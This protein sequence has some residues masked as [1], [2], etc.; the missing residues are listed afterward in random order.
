MLAAFLLWL[1]HVGAPLP[2]ILAVAAFCCGLLALIYA[3]TRPWR[4]I[5]IGLGLPLIAFGMLVLVLPADRVFLAAGCTGI[6]SGCA[7]A[8]IL[9]MERHVWPAGEE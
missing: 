2:Y 4:R 9:W 8:A 1:R 5:G 6:A 7:C 3:T